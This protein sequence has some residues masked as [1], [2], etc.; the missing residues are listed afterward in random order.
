MIK[1]ALLL[2]VFLSS[3]CLAQTVVRD[4]YGRTVAT[5]ERKTGEVRDRYGTM[6]GTIYKDIDNARTVPNRDKRHR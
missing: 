2:A 4:R 6:Q 1:V 3:T 5:Y